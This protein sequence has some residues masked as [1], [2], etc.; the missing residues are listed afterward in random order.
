MQVSLSLNFFFYPISL[1]RVGLNEKI[2]ATVG[3][4]LMSAPNVSLYALTIMAQPSFE[5]EEPDINNYQK[6]HRMV[7]LP[8]MHFLFGLCITGMFASMNSLRVRWKEFQKVKFSA[9][10]ATFC[11]PIVSHSTAVQAYRAAIISFS[12]YPTEGRFRKFLYCYWITVL[13]TGTIVT[14]VISV[15]FFL[16]LPSWTHV[17]TIDELEP[18]APN[19]TLMQLTDMISA[20]EA[21]VQPYVSP[22]VLHV[23]EAGALILSRNA[24][25]QHYVRSR[26]VSAIGFEPLLSVEEMETEREALLD[27]IGKNPRRRKHRTLNVPGIDFNYESALGSGH[28]SVQEM[29]EANGHWIQRPRS[30]TPPSS[31]KTSQYTELP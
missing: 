31:R 4:M 16:N 18:P 30:D 23:N 8:Y 7:Y 2:S 13:M 14:T 1:V 26:R 28:S 9:A 3:W 19:E 5:E 24:E 15:R 17:D 21:L 29:E 22:A 11:F 12:N 6:V 20:G 10:H 27:W 25:G